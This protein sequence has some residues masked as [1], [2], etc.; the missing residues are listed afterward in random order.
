LRDLTKKKPKR[1]D[2]KGQNAI[3]LL[4]VSSAAEIELNAGELRA[5]ENTHIAICG[6][7]GLPESVRG[8]SFQR[9]AAH[10]SLSIRGFADA[11]DR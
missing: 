2:R 7:R 4:V 3:V 10:N 6:L 11:S 5:A 9:D 8:T 1:E